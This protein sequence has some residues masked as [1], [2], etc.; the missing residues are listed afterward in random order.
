MPRTLFLGLQESLIIAE[1]TK[2]GW[3]TSQRLEGKAPQSI[4]LSGDIVFC[5]TFE[6]G[7]WKSEDDGDSWKKIGQEIRSPSV[8]AVALARSG[9]E[10]VLYAGT[11]P[12]SIYRSD[13]QGNTFREMEGMTRLDSS[14]TWSF[15][16]R[17]NTH[18]VRWIGPDASSPEHLYVAIEAGALVQSSDGGNIWI[19]RV[20]SGPFDTHTLATDFRKAGAVHSSAGDGYFESHDSGK[21]WK[22]LVSG[23]GYHRYCYGLALDPSNPANVVISCASSA[24]EAHYPG[25]PESYVYSKTDGENFRVTDGLPDPKGTFVSILCATKNEIYALNNR[26]VFSAKKSVASWTKLDIPWKKEYLSEHPWAL[27]AQD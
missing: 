6:D 4:A 27:A 20:P 18:H 9:S 19:D 3:K 2:S 1:E 7:L 22:R 10:T 5:A 24:F 15:P 14:K 16:P 21:S 11:E 8:M 13:D 12:S 26:G 25:S 23:L 17:P